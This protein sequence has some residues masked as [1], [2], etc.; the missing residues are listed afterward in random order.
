MGLVIF[1]NL[2][3][4]LSYFNANSLFSAKLKLAIM[5]A[6]CCFL[7]EISV[8]VSCSVCFSTSKLD[9]ESM[10][11]VKRIDS[12]GINC[13]KQAVSFILFLGFLRPTAYARP[14][15]WKPRRMRK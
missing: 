9:Y 8:V 5:I 10:L 11:R 4:I 2:V 7:S 6:S 15:N 1:S 13:R 12:V 14:G 3:L